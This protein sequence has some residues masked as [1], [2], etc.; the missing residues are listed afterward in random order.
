MIVSSCSNMDTANIFMIV[1]W[2]DDGRTMMLTQS[3][4]AVSV[5]DSSSSVLG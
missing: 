4:D 3:P 1:A 2:Q 5:M